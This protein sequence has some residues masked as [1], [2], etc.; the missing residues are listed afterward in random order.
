MPETLAPPPE[1]EPGAVEFQDVP[2][3]E[4]ETSELENE[5]E[6]E[7]VPEVV[8]P[9]PA[10]PV[11]IEASLVAASVDAVTPLPG[12]NWSEI[13]WSIDP[14]EPSEGLPNPYDLASLAPVDDWQ[15]GLGLPE[16]PASQRVA[17]LF[18]SNGPAVADAPKMSEVGVALAD[19]V[20]ELPSGPPTTAPPPRNH[21]LPSLPS[22]ER[23]KKLVVVATAVALA[24]LGILAVGHALIG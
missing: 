1:P 14:R 11:G 8:V 10:T 23:M 5:P 21:R 19:H 13:S 15:P 24:L 22:N 4:F 9:E 7:F 2:E 20:I 3:L 12:V 17:P 16:A 6:P 18:P